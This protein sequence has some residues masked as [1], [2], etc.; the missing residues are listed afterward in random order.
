MVSFF[1]HFATTTHCNFKFRKIYPPYCTGIVFTERSAASQITLWA[2]R[3]RFEP[4]T[5]RPSGRDS[6]TTLDPHRPEA[7]EALKGQPGVDR[8]NVGDADNS[9]FYRHQAAILRWAQT[10]QRA[11]LLRQLNAG[12]HHREVDRLIPVC[13]NVSILRV[14]RRFSVRFLLLLL[15]LLNDHMVFGEAQ[16]RAH[17][18]RSAEYFLFQVRPGLLYRSILKYVKEIV[19]R[20]FHKSL[21]C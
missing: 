15:E 20:D 10:G 5:D 9:S 6:L 17:S 18:F 12:P 19:L 2:P 14:L 8:P 1:W 21:Q 4:V 3:P 7:N 11:Q 16:Q 13:S